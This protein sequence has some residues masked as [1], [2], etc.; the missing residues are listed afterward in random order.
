MFDIDKERVI[1]MKEEVFFIHS[2]RVGYRIDKQLLVSLEEIF[3]NYN[4]TTTLNIDVECDNNILYKFESVNE[5]CDFFD[6]NPYRIV[7]MEIRALLGEGIDANQVKLVFSNKRY[8]EARISYRFN[9]NDD[10]LVMK[11]KIEMYLKNYKLN[12]SLLSIIPITPIMFFSIFIAIY[13]YTDINHIVFPSIIQRVIIGIWVIGSCSGIL[14]SVNKLKRNIFPCFEFRIGQN[15]IV[16][17]NYS[18]IRNILIG[19]ISIGII[20]GIIVNFV[21]KV[22]GI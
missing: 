11:N 2:Y 6:N 18:K 9:S 20:V 3:K 22:L 7:K 5:T 16:E 14:P 1:N 15:K 13:I 12:Y 8:S 19:A 17:D 4:S 10:Y 21:S